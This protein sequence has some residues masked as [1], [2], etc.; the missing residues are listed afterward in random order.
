MS[1]LRKPLYLKPTFGGQPNHMLY[2]QTPRGG[3]WR[4]ICGSSAEAKVTLEIALEIALEEGWRKK[5]C[6]GSVLPT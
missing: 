4:K 2:A 5:K 6:I 3:S 1:Y